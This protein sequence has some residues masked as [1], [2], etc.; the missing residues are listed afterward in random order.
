MNQINNPYVGEMARL[1]QAVGEAMTDSMVERLTSTG[2]NALEVVDR[3]NDSETK[4]AVLSLIDALTMMHKTGALSTLVECATLLHAARSAM[5]DS[6]VD[7]L[8]A[9]VEHMMTNL[10]TE[11]MATMA[12]EAKAAMEDALESCAKRPAPKSIFGLVGMLNNPD[13]LQALNFLLSFSCKLR[14]RATVLS[15][16][17]D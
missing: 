8:M 11:D 4:D 15:K 2:A 12:H 5:T 10:A 1:T 16:H 7:R 13:T 6:M 14:Q 9:F 3:L 17:A